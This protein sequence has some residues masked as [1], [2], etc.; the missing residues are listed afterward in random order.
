[1]LGDSEPLGSSGA[2]ARQRSDS[3]GDLR[4]PG[5]MQPLAGARRSSDGSASA[6][7][8]SGPWRAQSSEDGRLTD[9]ASE[10]TADFDSPRAAG[11]DDDDGSIPSGPA[12]ADGLSAQ[13]QIMTICNGSA[14]H[15]KAQAWRCEDMRSDS[16]TALEVTPRPA[17]TSSFGS[18]SGSD[19]SNASM[20]A[21]SDEH[22]TRLTPRAWWVPLI[23]HLLALNSPL[24][25]LP[26]GG[27]T[28]RGC[29]VQGVF[30]GAS[31]SRCATSPSKGACWQRGDDGFIQVSSSII[32]LVQLLSARARTSLVVVAAPTSGG[33]SS[34]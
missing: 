17:A 14:R 18:I 19:Q 11:S 15:R 6:S 12:A 8:S 3:G 10:Y 32:S 22:Q 30:A 24:R 33:G 28:P 16:A 29:C 23:Q 20:F 34:M 9:S 31:H 2:D 25:P 13:R 7:E 5:G 4:L 21:Y 1:M 26:A 27:G